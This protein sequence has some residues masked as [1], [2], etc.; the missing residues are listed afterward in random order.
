[1]GGEGL[2]QDPPV[3]GERFGITLRAELVQEPR[4]ALDVREEEGDGSGGEIASHH[5]HDAREP[6]FCH[7]R[8]SGIRAG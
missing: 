4:R 7:A 2:A 1:V 5:R 6:G 3:L 8:N